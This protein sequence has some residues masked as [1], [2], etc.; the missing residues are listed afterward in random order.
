[1]CIAQNT[2]V[3]TLL[4][5]RPNTWVRNGNGNPITSFTVTIAKL[6]CQEIA[7]F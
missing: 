6:S 3:D 1:M 4:D 5:W 2:A 7:R